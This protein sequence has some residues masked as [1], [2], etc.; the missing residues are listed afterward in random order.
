MDIIVTTPKSQIANAAQEAADC[1]AEGGGVYFRRFSGGVPNINVGERVFYIEDGFVRGYA[2]VCRVAN[3]P[4]TM[5]CDTTGRWYDPG[6][7]V[8]MRAD[9]WRWIHPIPMRGTPGF[10]YARR[11]G[12]NPNVLAPFPDEDRFAYI[13]DIGGWLDGKPVLA[14]TRSMNAHTEV[15]VATP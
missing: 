13:C 1:I 11:P 15:P 9:S 3:V 7:Y 5:Q 4:H 2:I 6:F 10:R 8:F 14:P 12:Q